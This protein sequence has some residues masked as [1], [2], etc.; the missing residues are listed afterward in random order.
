MFSNLLT[1][2]SLNNNKN[3]GESPDEWQIDLL[4][5]LFPQVVS[6]GDFWTGQR[7]FCQVKRALSLIY[8]HVFIIIIIFI[9]ISIIIIIFIIIIIIMTCSPLLLLMLMWQCI[10]D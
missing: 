9:V 1:L 2:L 6:S 4:C 5:E 3:N 7:Q 10:S 8:I